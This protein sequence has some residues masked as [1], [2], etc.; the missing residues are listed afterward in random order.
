MRSLARSLE[1]LRLSRWQRH[2]SWCRSPYIVLCLYEPLLQ[3]LYVLS[4]F[5][6]MLFRDHGS[7]RRD[8]S[9]YLYSFSYTPGSRLCVY[10]CGE[11]PG[12]RCLKYIYRGVFQKNAGKR[13]SQFLGRLLPQDEAPRNFSVVQVR[14]SLLLLLLLRRYNELRESVHRIRRRSAPRIFVKLRGMAAARHWG[15]SYWFDCVPGLREGIWRSR[16][17]LCV[18]LNLGLFLVWSLYTEA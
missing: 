9:V 10:V 8:H 12:H 7:R 15:E 2:F 5:A 14:E 3:V 4:P 17:I 16:A 1:S 18:M 13:E 11:V 6:W